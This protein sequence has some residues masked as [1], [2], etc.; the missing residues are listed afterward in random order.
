MKILITGGHLT[1]ALSF[2]DFVSKKHPKDKLIFVG[3][4]FSQDVLQQRAVER[5]EVEKRKIPFISF[6]AVRFGSYFFRQPIGNFVRFLRSFRE[7]RKLLRKHQPTVVL[8]FGGYVAVPLV[9]AAKL[10][11]IPVVTHEQTLTS[12]F[13]NKLI[14]W[15]ADRVAV[16]FPETKQKFDQQKTVITGNPLRAGVF[17]SRH[18]RPKWLPEKIKLPILLVM[19]G[20]QGS[21]SI[22]QAIAKALPELLS[23]WLIIHQCGRP[24]AKQQ[25]QQFLERHRQRLP[26]KLQERYLILEWIDDSDLFW[27]Y[28]HALGAISRSGANATQELAAANLPSIL[29][30][31]PFSHHQEQQKNA[32]W[33]VTQGGAILLEQ[34]AL[35]TKN[36]LKSL[37]KLKTLAEPMRESLAEINLPQN[38][39]YK[40]Y[41][42]VSAVK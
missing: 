40:L 3:R 12:G 22:N 21:W 30:P 31:L 35:N 6:Q 24:T 19:G 26:K 38:A 32:R 29:V 14:G 28:Q 20:N 25:Y 23:D 13:A 33:L 42:V 8:S 39:A 7:A 11:K 2:I 10:E 34:S 37:E 15:F 27:L 1:P 18:P 41:E 5:Y 36:L 17:R 4:E 9:L 16:S